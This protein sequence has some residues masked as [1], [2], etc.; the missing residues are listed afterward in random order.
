MRCSII[1][2]VVDEE[3]VTD[4]ETYNPN[5]R[6][7]VLIVLGELTQA[8]LTTERDLDAIALRIVEKVNEAINSNI[9]MITGA[10]FTE[11]IFS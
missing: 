3:A 9:T 2:Q 11:F 4:L 1:F 5:I 8:E 10:Y 6:N 7:A